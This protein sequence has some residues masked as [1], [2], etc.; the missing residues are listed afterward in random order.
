MCSDHPYH[1][2]LPLLALAN[3]TKVGSGVSG[4]FAKDFLENVG[5]SKVDPAKDII[6]RLK[7]EA[8]PYVTEL[9]D[10]YSR[11][12]DSYIDLAGADTSSFQRSMTKNIS[13]STIS[14][15]TSTPLDKS[16][17]RH[18]ARGSY[19]PAIFTAPPIL[20]PTAKYH[21][22]DGCLVGGE[23]ITGFKSTFDITETGLHRPKIVVCYGSNGGEYRQ[24]VKGEDE[25]RQD[26]IMSQV[27]QVV[28]SLLARLRPGSDRK[29]GPRSLN[30]QLRMATYN[31]V[32]LSPASGVLEWVEN[33]IAFGDII[34]GKATK[35]GDVGLHAKYYPKEWN[36][37]L[38]R[39]HFAGA[40]PNLKRETFEIVCRHFSAC[41]RFFFVEQF[42]HDMMKWHA[43][44]MR[45]TRSVAVSSMVGHI[46]GI[47]DR[48][49]SNIL[50][51]SHTGE[52]VHIDFGIVFEQGKV[53]SWYRRSL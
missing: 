8:A 11:L 20:Q 6:S 40:P 31:V 43:A 18:N 7:K 27:F 14:S 36:Y 22:S 12:S 42:G 28:N 21:E 29:T 48:H 44:R 32:P 34:V 35:G 3:G 24:L 13:F 19:S 16:I 41:F 2:L 37:L 45:Y 17:G 4:R 9:L 53:S 50:V 46:L 15:G 51:H 49:T 26:A 5:N 39:K 25:I 47:G 23:R 1:C 30:H 38:C 33:T 10:G 52:I